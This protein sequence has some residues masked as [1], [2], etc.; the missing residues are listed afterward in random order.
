MADLWQ[1]LHQFLLNYGDRILGAVLILAAGWLLMRYLVGPLRRLLARGPMDPLVASFLVNSLRTVLLFA[2][3]LGVLNQLGVETTSLL[4][5]LGA[6]ALAVSLSLQGSLANFASG[7][8]ILWFRIVRVGDQIESGDIKGRVVELLP[9]HAVLLTADN[10]RVTIPN[11]LLTNGPVRNHSAQPTHRCEWNL[12]VKAGE[13]LSAVKEGLR[14]CLRKDPRI[15]TDPPPQVFVKEW[16]ED[17]R[18]LTAT[19]W[20][21]TLDHQA[22]QQEMLEAL[23]L[24]LEE[25]RK[26]EGPSPPE[27]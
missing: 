10:Q 23:G 15:L 27:K 12:P 3:L 20:T 26:A 9:F 16:A 11:T 19:A 5:L 14:A 4:T 22:V 25:L 17:K 6:L 8:L 21:I 7:L 13:D 1:T 24:S 18:I 2:V